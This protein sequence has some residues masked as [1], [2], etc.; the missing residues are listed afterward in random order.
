MLAAARQ[1]FRT[2][3]SQR[4]DEFKEAYKDARKRAQQE[5]VPFNPRMVLLKPLIDF[6]AV[7]LPDD[8]RTARHFAKLFKFHMV[9]KLVLIGNHEWRSPG[10]IQ[11]FDEM[12]SDAIFADFIGSYAKLPPSIAVPTLGSP[13]FVHPQAVVATDFRLIGYRIAQVATQVMRLPPARRLLASEMLEL[14][15]DSGKPTGDGKLFAGDRHVTWPTYLFDVQR[16]GIRL[17]TDPP[18]YK[19]LPIAERPANLPTISS[20]WTPATTNR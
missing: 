19:S 18:I 12:F 14:A 17:E 4:R 13:Y 15:G 20:G 16:R 6:D 11:P 5:G 1:L 7:F 8:F 3:V 2:D 9:N 10:L